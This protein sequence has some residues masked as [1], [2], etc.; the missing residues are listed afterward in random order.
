MDKELSPNEKNSLNKY[1]NQKLESM[2]S[3]RITPTYKE[4]SK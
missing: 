3:V 2:F 1:V 4:S